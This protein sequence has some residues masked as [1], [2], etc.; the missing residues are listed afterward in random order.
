MTMRGVYVGDLYLPGHG[1][2]RAFTDL[3]STAYLILAAP[4]GLELYRRR[5]T[6][7]DS[8]WRPKAQHVTPPSE[9]APA[10]DGQLAFDL[11]DPLALVD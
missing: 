2:C 3:D 5:S 4:R 1:L 7:K 6:I 11:T 9:L 8:W 10:P